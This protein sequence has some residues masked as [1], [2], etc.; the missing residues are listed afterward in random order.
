M[1]MNSFQN[2]T[3]TASFL[4]PDPRLLPQGL[5]L[6]KPFPKSILVPS[7]TVHSYNMVLII[8]SK[9]SCSTIIGLITS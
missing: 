7:A 5:D 9:L 4:H 2:S 1:R 3:V 8:T 6:L